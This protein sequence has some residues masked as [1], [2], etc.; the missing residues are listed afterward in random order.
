MPLPQ[1]HPHPTP[2]RQRSAAA[3]SVTVAVGDSAAVSDP[4]ADMVEKFFDR[5]DAS[6][7]DM[8]AGS[9]VVAFGRRIFRREGEYWTIVYDEAVCRVP[10]SRGLQ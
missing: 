2:N 4:A 6:E 3:A 9:A 10:D 5:S 7:P 1:L 8:H